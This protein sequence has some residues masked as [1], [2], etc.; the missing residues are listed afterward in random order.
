[1]GDLA[2][3]DR[4][5]VSLREHVK[6]TRMSKDVH[7][8]LQQRSVNATG[9]GEDVQERDF[10]GVQDQELCYGAES[11]NQL[12]LDPLTGAWAEI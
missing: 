8:G 9:L 10:I 3:V 6:G 12:S 5:M 11:P 2:E 7:V 4:A 1:M